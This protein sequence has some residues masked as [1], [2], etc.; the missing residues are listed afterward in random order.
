MNSHPWRQKR[1][2]SSGWRSCAERSCS[3]R[4]RFRRCIPWQPIR[5]ECWATTQCRCATCGGA[6][7][8]RYGNSCAGTK[9]LS[10][11]RAWRHSY[12][13][14]LA[15]NRWVDSYDTQHRLLS[16]LTGPSDQLHADEFR[17][18]HRALQSGHKAIKTMRTH[19]FEQLQ[20][21]H[22]PAFRAPIPQSIIPV[23]SEN[24]I[25]YSSCQ[26]LL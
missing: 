8:G 23:D 2:G 18:L 12:V 25:C 26:N 22:I 24:R 17:R 9:S 1:S 15:G 20:D 5:G 10:G 19:R 4:H 3:P 6:I 7:A 16:I 21:S 11:Q 13:H 14:I